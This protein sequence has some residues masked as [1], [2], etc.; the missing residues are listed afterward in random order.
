MSASLDIASS[1]VVNR[2][3]YLSYADHILNISGVISVFINL[4]YA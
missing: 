1:F 4:A 2:I 3:H